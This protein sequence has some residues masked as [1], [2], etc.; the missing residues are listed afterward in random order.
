VTG[1]GPGRFPTSSNF[2]AARGGSFADHNSHHLNIIAHFVAQKIARSIDP[3]L[4]RS[5]LVL[6]I[7]AI[8]VIALAFHISENERRAISFGQS[9]DGPF[10]LLLVFPRRPSPHPAEIQVQGIEIHQFL[11]IR[12]CHQ[13]LN[14]TRRR[15][16]RFSAR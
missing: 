5:S 10:S 8:L 16:L 1:L 2:S 3:R 12:R 4:Y 9:A 14:D 15:R 7:A 11:A 13:A 6:R